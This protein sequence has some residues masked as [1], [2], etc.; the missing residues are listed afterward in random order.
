M[1]PRVKEGGRYRL[2]NGYIVVDKLIPIELDEVSSKMAEESGFAD[3]ADLLKTAR[4]GKGDNVYLIH[5]HYVE[6]DDYSDLRA[7]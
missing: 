6:D 4:H 1:R 3:I 2:E 5:F 7:T